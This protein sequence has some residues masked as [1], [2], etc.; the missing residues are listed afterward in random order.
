ME[1]RELTI[2]S[3][4]HPIG[5]DGH[6]W[7]SW[8]LDSDRQD[9]LQ[10]SWQL[11]VTDPTGRVLMDTGAVQNRK[12]AYI[13]FAGKPLESRTEYRV[14]LTVTDNHG[15]TA[16]KQG[17]FETGLLHPEDWQGK[18]I[19]SPKKRKKPGVGF[20]KQFPSTLLCQD[21]RVKGPIQKARL[22]ATAHGVY[23]AY[24]NGTR[25]DERTF[26]PEH[27]VYKKY[28]CV[29]TYDLTALLSQGA[30]TVGFHVGDGWYF[31]PNAKPNMRTDQQHAVLFQLELLYA[32][33]S[34]EVVGSDLSALT[35]EGPVL[36]SD[37]YAGE[38]YDAAREIPGWA[39]PNRQ[40]TWTGV[41]SKD[42]G[43]DN[44]VPQC[45]DRV[46]PVEMFPVRQVLR[47]PKGECIL[48][49]GQ[50]I[51][52]RIRV[53]MPLQ[54]GQ[55]LRLEHCEVLDKT[56]NYM[57]N[58][59]SAGGVG[60]GC[61]QTDEYRADGNL[62][63]YEPHFTYHG[64]RY[65]RVTVDGKAP[66][67][68]DPAWFTAVLLSSEKQNVG[69]FSCSDEKLNRLYQNIR[70][71]QYSNM[72]SIPTDCP[73]REKAGWTGDM[74]V[75][76]KTALLNEDCTVLFSRWLANLAL[77]QDKYGIVPMVVPEN[78]AYP[79]MGMLMNRAFGGKG[80]GTSSGWGDAAVL[81]P[82]TMYQVTGNTG[83]LKAQYNSMRH[84]VEFIVKTAREKKPTKCLRPA[85][86]EQYL[87]DTGFHYG[88]WLVPSQSKNG[89]DPKHMKEFMESSS[90]YTAPIFGWYS[91]RTFAEI[92]RILAAEQPGSTVFPADAAKYQG[93][94]EKMKHAI[95]VGVIQPDGSMPS[96][97]MGAYVLPIALDLVPEEHKERFAN[98]LVRSIEE[99]GGC[100]DTG[101]LATPYL[102]D[103]LCKIGRQDMAYEM[104]FQTKTPSWISEVLAGGTTIWENCFGYDDQGNPGTLSFN[105]YAFGCVADW[106]YRNIN[107]IVP[108]DA[109]Y[110]KVRI[111]PK[112]DARLTEAH[113][114]YESV[115]GAISVDWSIQSRGSGESV[116]HLA[117]RIPCNCQAAVVLPGGT[118][119]DVGS[120][121][122]EYEEKLPGLHA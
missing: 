33:G 70:Y 108:L 102:L 44:L 31:C 58:I 48:D 104:L 27:T 76:G 18:W 59:M 38:L 72:I 91:V 75:Y 4:V 21:L 28:L 9:T 36:S 118:A 89:L 16:A 87:W 64:F 11:R 6:P 112:L 117:V 74:Q 8:K 115:N 73:Q 49:F 83:I 39:T 121:V 1:I 30:N 79:Q 68:V 47:S 55:C 92:C 23:E 66:E 20:G 46:I 15:N 107:G 97:L 71:S 14:D 82:Y 5:T 24:L 120:G 86:I 43:L 122:Y 116:Y 93:I 37:L 57:N 10:E 101:F 80:K 7:F 34:R 96:N 12:N 19:L 29:Q 2:V 111:E 17:F 99:N 77:D 113:R 119:H 40:G 114:T 45:G 52:G 100:M 65:A 63:S 54:K 95:Q 51:A 67:T 60:K 78:G 50:N 103:A 53:S 61:D 3:S 62:V 85:E 35:A 106:M 105:H 25:V 42:Y 110:R 26:A 13:A 81:V 109:G 69:T 98:A 94:A 90:C 41:K 56:G 84:W 88:E 32:D 22:Y